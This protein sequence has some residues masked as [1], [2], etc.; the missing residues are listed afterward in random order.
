MLYN[1]VNVLFFFSIM[2]KNRLTL[3][4][5]IFPSINTNK[6]LIIMSNNQYQRKLMESKTSVVM[7]LI[8]LGYYI[9]IV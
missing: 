5:S 7:F 3:H 4:L 1:N 9:H 6:Y 8:I 2:C